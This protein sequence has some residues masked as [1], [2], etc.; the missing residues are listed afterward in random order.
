M[1]T[2]T[3]A[4]RTSATS[5]APTGSR[6]VARPYSVRG[7]FFCMK[8]R[9]DLRQRVTDEISG[10]SNGGGSLLGGGQHGGG[11]ELFSSE[12]NSSIKEVGVEEIFWGLPKGGQP[13]V[14]WLRD[15]W[16]PGAEEAQ[17]QHRWV[18]WSQRD[19]GPAFTWVWYGAPGYLQHLLL[20]VRLT[21]KQFSIQLQPLW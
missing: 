18:D 7:K 9:T 20:L 13:M 2:S 14:L 4:T 15:V 19:A 3:L 17:E 16:S 10:T 1:K 12:G 5:A 8:F 21:N 6:L 11:V